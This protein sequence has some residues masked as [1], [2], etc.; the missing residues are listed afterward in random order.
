MKNFVSLKLA[1]NFVRTAVSTAVF[2]D[3][4]ALSRSA[5]A[6]KK[7][8]DRL[9]AA[10]YKKFTDSKALKVSSV[11]RVQYFNRFERLNIEDIA[12]KIAVQIPVQ[13]Y[14]GKKGSAFAL[15]KRYKVDMKAKVKPVGPT[16]V[17]GCPENMA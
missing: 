1:V 3:N 11:K 13:L 6:P 17:I 16:N 4:N 7:F 9:S 10:S 15:E 14:R 5:C 12:K 8:L 2:N